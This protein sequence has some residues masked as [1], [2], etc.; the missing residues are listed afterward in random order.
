MTTPFLIRLL[1]F[2][3]ARGELDPPPSS[4]E[5]PRPGGLRRRTAAALSALALAAGAALGALA[6]APRVAPAEVASDVERLARA[7]EEAR[8][9][10]LVA[11]LLAAGVTV[12]PPWFDTRELEA[13]LDTELVTAGEIGE[14]ET[15]RAEARWLARLV[16]PEDLGERTFE[17]LAFL[18]GGIHWY[19][20]LVARGSGAEGPPHEKAAEAYDPTRL[21]CYRDMDY[22]D[23]LGSWD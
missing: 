17:D 5:P 3:R 11:G 10:C 1:P 9:N 22:Q 12:D 8:D 16:A 20:D 21:C 2:P 18:T 15:L 19:L 7:R 23:L 13:A 4:G 14:V 6:T